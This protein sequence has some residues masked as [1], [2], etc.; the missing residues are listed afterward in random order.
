MAQ[1]RRRYRVVSP[2]LAITDGDPAD[3]VSDLHDRTCRCPP[4]LGEPL[5]FGQNSF[6]LAEVHDRFNAFRASIASGELRPACAGD[7]RERRAL[8]SS[9]SSDKFSVEFHG[10]PDPGCRT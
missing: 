2:D 10:Q 4:S 6:V 8:I 7:P 3:R 5:P 1:L 9:A